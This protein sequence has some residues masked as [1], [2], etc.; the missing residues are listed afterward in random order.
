M[1]IPNVKAMVAKAVTVGMVAGALMLAG[2]TKAQAQQFGFGV[3]FGGPR[4]VQPA[5]GFWAR[6]AWEREQIARREAAIRHE[7]W[8]RAHRF[9][10]RPHGGGYGYYGR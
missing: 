9:E 1:K 4:Y 7:E 10:G 8:V 5:P 3:Q 6:R 2:P